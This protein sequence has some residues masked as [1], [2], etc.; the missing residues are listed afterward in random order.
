MFAKFPVALANIEIMMQFWLE[1]LKERATYK[2]EI[3][4]EGKVL[5]LIRIR[6]NIAIWIQSVQHKVKWL[7]FLNTAT[8]FWVS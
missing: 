7:T 4:V 3:V 6:S 2:R 8:G 5:Y 1:H